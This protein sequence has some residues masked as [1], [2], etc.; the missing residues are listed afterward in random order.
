M[1]KNF[2]KSSEIPDLNYIFF[3]NNRNP[4]ARRKNA[5]SMILFRFNSKEKNIQITFDPRI[6]R[7]HALDGKLCR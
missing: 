5:G 7:S 1:K 3:V 2:T 4:P 6:P